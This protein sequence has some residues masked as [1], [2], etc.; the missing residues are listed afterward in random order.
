M[1]CIYRLFLVPFLMCDLWSLEVNC[2]QMRL[3]QIFAKT[4]LMKYFCMG[5][6]LK[7]RIIKPAEES[8]VELEHLMAK[9]VMLKPSE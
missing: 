9:A 3:G 8:R 6:V 7:A 5:V 4:L 2:R 1:K